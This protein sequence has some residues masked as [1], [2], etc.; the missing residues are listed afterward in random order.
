LAPGLVLRRF[1]CSDLL[2]VMK[3]IAKGA[4]QVASIKGKI[5]LREIAAMPPGPFLMWDTE[6]R[7][8]NVRRQFSRA[9]TYSV[10][11]RANDGRQHWL[12]IGRHGV[13]TP[14]L[15]REKAKSVLLAV[16]MGKDPSAE[17]HALRSGATI[18]ELVDEYLADLDTH[19]LNGKK[20][21]T[22]KSDKSRIE[23]H[24]RPRL[25]KLRV[26]AI[27]QLQIENFM[28]DCPPGSARTIIAM[29]SSIF[30]FAI[31]KKLRSDNPCKGIVKPKD[32]RKTR[33]LSLAEYAQLGTAIGN[34]TTVAND[35]FLFLAVSG[36]RSSEARLLK[37]SEID[38]ERRIATLADTK[39][40]VSIRPLSRAA[41]EI[42]KRQSSQSE[43]VFALQQ[44]RPATNLFPPWKKLQMPKDVTQHT[45]RH[46]FASLS[47][48]MGYS[49]NVIAGMLGHARSSITSR[50]VH[51]EKALI[52]SADAVAV[53]TLRLMSPL[54]GQ[55]S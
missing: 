42:I 44:G 15:A 40:G 20:A 37:H 2:Y 51:L 31:K 5:G 12:K 38:L 1:S 26:A 46:S 39:T 24:I 55:C 49:D 45:L 41:I 3:R 23:N 7:G 10:I 19:K 6:I 36:W 22:K 30:T 29:L 17:R 11:Y 25:G 16:D 21:S 34:S 53:E 32:N 35:I 27:T 43:Y 50:Y 47:A 52:E 9:I 33:R 48:D 8:F 54:R 14:T 18:A 28:N 4:Q 13:W